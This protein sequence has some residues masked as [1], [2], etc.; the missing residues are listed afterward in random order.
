MGK[1]IMWK[2][3]GKDDN[4]DKEKWAWRW[5]P[6]KSYKKPEKW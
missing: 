2:K 4:I 1:K 6:K 5:S 3:K